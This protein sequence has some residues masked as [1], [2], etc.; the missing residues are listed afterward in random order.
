[1]ATAMK[2]LSKAVTKLVDEV[3]TTTLDKVVEFAKG[4]VS[5]VEKFTADLEEFKKTLKQDTA[6]QYSPAC[7]SSKKASSERKK[8]T[9][10]E[11]NTFIGTK[12]KELKEKNA[13]K[14]GKE[15][16]KLAIEAWKARPAK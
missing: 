1:M 15:L 8:R 4:Y 10:S 5:D 2:N 6:A 14:D 11:Y 9:P 12:I 13:D 16:M 3:Q 7:E